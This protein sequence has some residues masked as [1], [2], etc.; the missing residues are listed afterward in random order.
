MNP[1]DPLNHKTHLLLELQGLA[2]TWTPLQVT[3]PPTL[4]PLIS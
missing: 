2:H 1:N 4:T 3:N